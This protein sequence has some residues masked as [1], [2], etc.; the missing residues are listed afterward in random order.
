MTG[1]TVQRELLRRSTRMGAGVKRY[2]TWPTI[3]QQTVADHTMNVLRIWCELF[4]PPHSYV[5]EHI[6]Y[7]DVGESGAGDPPFPSKQ[8]WPAL[9]DGHDQAE[10][11]TL[12]GMGVYIYASDLSDIDRTKIKVCDLLEMWEFGL[13]EWMLGSRYAEAVVVDTLTAALERTPIVVVPNVISWCRRTQE[14][15]CGGVPHEPTQLIL[16]GMWMREG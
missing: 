8:L 10:R 6:L 3:Q 13:T 16:D 5:T 2:H 11:E 7:H 9:K 15:L 1:G 12:E 14:R 4:G